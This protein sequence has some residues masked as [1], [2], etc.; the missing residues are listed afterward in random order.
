MPEPIAGKCDVYVCPICKTESWIDS[1]KVTHRKQW[2][3]KCDHV[4]V[5]GWS[6]NLTE[7]AVVELIAALKAENAELE[8]LIEKAWNYV[9]WATPDDELVAGPDGCSCVEDGG[10][11]CYVCA[12]IRY[13]K[14]RP[15]RD[16][17]E[18]K[19]RIAA[20]VP[21]LSP[22]YLAG[23]NDAEE[24]CDHCEEGRCQAYRALTPDIPPKPSAEEGGED[25]D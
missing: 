17:E 24:D 13:F 6:I 16:C 12:F 10:E 2:L 3:L 21:W 4:C 25:E 18:L 1:F 9:K 11:E 20:A 14:N 8:G 23:C 22:Y 15:C 7:G 5:T 19:E